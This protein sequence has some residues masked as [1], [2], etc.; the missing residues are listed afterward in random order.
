MTDRPTDTAGAILN[1]RI[2]PELKRRLRRA[3]IKLAA[4]DAN[5]RL[6]ISNAARE[7]LEEGIAIVEGRLRRKPAA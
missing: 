2:T 7:C 3:A 4:S 1:L 6:S 5:R